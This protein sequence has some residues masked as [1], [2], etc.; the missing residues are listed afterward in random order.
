MSW[1]MQLVKRAN[2]KATVRDPGALGV[3]TMTENKFVFSPN[4]HMSTAAKPALDVEFKQITC[5]KNTKEGGDRPPWLRLSEKDKTYIFE[6]ASFRDLHVC[7]EFA[8]NAL[9]KRGEAA[10]PPCSSDE[11]ICTAEIMHRMKLLQESSELHK[12]HMQYV[13]SGVL[14]E[15][16]FWAARNQFGDVDSR[17]KPKQRV[18]FRNS[19]IMDTKP[20]TD[21]RTNKVTF[22][23]TAEIKYQIFA[24]KPAVQQAFLAL[25]PSKTTEK[26]FWTKYFR[27][28]YLRST[29]NAAAA[30]AEAADDEELAMFLKEDEVLAREARRKLRRVDPTLDMEA[31]QGDDYTHLPDHGIFFRDEVYSRRSTLSQDLN[32]QGAV[33]LQGRSIVEVDESGV[34]GGFGRIA[35]TTEMEDLQEPH[36]LHVAQ[37]LCMK[38]PGDYFDTQQANNAVKTEEAYGS[39]RQSISKIKSIG[40]G[41]S[42]VAAEI[43]LTIFNA[44]SF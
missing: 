7:R 12:L 25:V 21:G 38:D 16:E 24:L 13:M 5:L 6:F 18:G 8:A 1:C 17:P 40:L 23:L 41:N 15:A 28:E 30:E 36:H 27:A 4:V 19:M 34:Q 42:T 11:Q 2:Y 33:V 32:R 10:I 26:N 31:D 3:L 14:T 43:A 44:T 9:A 20:M 22:S 29:G 39:L 35:R 37:L